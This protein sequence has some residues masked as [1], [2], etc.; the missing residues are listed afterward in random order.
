MIVEDPSE[1][2]SDMRDRNDMRYLNEH[3]A[4]DGLVPPVP[5]E[6]VKELC[7]EYKLTNVSL[8]WTFK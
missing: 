4:F 8:F 6:K 1:D 2:F 3:H 5:H 7:R